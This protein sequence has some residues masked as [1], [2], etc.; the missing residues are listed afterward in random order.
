MVYRTAPPLSFCSRRPLTPAQAPAAR[1]N[2]SSS[3]RSSNSTGRP[4]S[5]T[6]SSYRDAPTRAVNSGSSNPSNGYVAF[7][8]SA[9]NQGGHTQSPGPRKSTGT[10]TAPVGGHS[11][12]RPVGRSES[13]ERRPADR[14]YAA[15]NVDYGCSYSTV[16][17]NGG[18]SEN[19]ASHARASPNGDLREQ[20]DRLTG[21][22]AMKEQEVAWLR[23][24][25]TRLLGRGAFQRNG[26]PPPEEES[27]GRATGGSCG[28]IRLRLPDPDRDELRRHAVLGGNGGVYRASLGGFTFAVKVISLVDPKAVKET[29][30]LQQLEHPNIV[31]YLG[32]QQISPQELHLFMEYLPLSLELHMQTLLAAGRRFKDREMARVA[33]EVTKGLHYL[34]N[35]ATA[36]IIHRD[37]KSKNILLDVDSHGEIQE[38]KLCDFGVS[39]ILGRGCMA[40]TMVGT[41]YWMP[42]EILTNDSTPYSVEADIWSLGMVFVELTTLHNPYHELKSDWP[43]IKRMILSGQPPRVDPSAPSRFKQLIHACLRLWPEQRPSTRDIMLYL[44]E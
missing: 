25:N 44:T 16:S 22:L 36:K 24:E 12:A 43:A 23:I 34:H 29:E 19:G 7:R 40:D 35:T 33:L 37:L 2:S 20:L 14:S 27:R 38:V 30:I 13:I 10:P 15:E 41:Y 1:T 18:G 17:A 31:R 11:A 42:P 39:R 21:L 32:S 4:L 8:S 6:G 3:G 26:P 9:A 28:G 5:D